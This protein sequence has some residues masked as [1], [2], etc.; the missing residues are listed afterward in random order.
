MCNAY[1]RK[2]VKK[3]VVQNSYTCALGLSLQIV[4]HFC[5]PSNCVTVAS[6]TIITRKYFTSLKR[7]CKILLPDCSY[8]LKPPCVPLSPAVVSSALCHEQQGTGV[9]A[10]LGL[11]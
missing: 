6:I 5:V 11:F 1:V 3:A 10:E 4:L 9:S 7:N 2:K 8:L